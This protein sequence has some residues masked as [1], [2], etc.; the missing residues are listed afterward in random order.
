M[1]TERPRDLALRILTDLTRI[2]HHSAPYLDDIFNQN[3]H[4][5]N[6]DRAFITH[7]VLGVLR[8]R[9]RLD[10][11]IGQYANLPLKKISS[12]VLNILRIG[13]YQIF[14]MDRVPE[15]AAVNE[16]VNQ[17]KTKKSTRHAA[18]FV[19]GILR[20]ICRQKDEIAFPDK[21][22]NIEH[23]LAV[24]YSYPQWVVEK[25]I[26]ELGIEHTESLLSAQNRIPELNIRSNSLRISRE[27]LI[28]SLA[29]E[30]VM[31]KPTTYAP[32]GILLE[33]FKGRVDELS[34][35]SKGLFQVQ[36]QAAQITSYLLAPRSG[37]VVLDLCAGLGG[38]STHL[39]ELMGGNGL[40]VALDITRKRLISLSRNSQR[41]GITDISPLVVDATRD[42]SCLFS[43]KFDSIMV[44]APCSGLGVISH[45]PDGKWNRDE[46]DIIRLALLQ[47]NILSRA[48][49]VLRK[50]GRMLYVTCTIS[51]EENEGVVR[52]VLDS[53][54][55][56][57]L[58]N[59]R[60]YVPDWGL[61]LID[62]QGFMKTFPHIHHMDGFFAALFKKR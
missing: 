32:D 17:T 20:N 7:L 51:K 10:W 57:F 14:Y 29:K 37:D 56:V 41:L 43:A 49:S 54:S 19:N 23:Y 35:F 30:G 6:R 46:R 15:S 4:L 28:D 50:G 60:N 13:L 36:D 24:S 9:L 12:Q 47:K 62:D 2:S 42:L 21:D 33:G 5:N 26:R 40:V 8:W 53:R 38:K 1:K 22:S 25:W 52:D 61:E 45:N 16:A 39:A 31:A 59:L 44:D 58:E 34:S 3:P 27:K 11:I 55:D 48:V 18:A